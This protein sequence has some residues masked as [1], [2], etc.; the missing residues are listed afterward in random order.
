MKI[1]TD[2]WVERRWPDYTVENPD[3]SLGENL[4]DE[5]TDRPAPTPDEF[6][7]GMQLVYAALLAGTVLLSK[8]A[9]ELATFL[10]RN[11]ADAV[12]EIGEEIATARL[13]SEQMTASLRLLEARAFMAAMSLGARA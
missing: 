8:D 1:V 3:E 4:H 11:G 12:S 7:D 6:R 13:W 9:D 5:L 2:G 10:R